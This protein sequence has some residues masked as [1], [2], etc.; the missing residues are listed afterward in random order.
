MKKVLAPV[1]HHDLYTNT[2]QKDLIGYFEEVLIVPIEARLSDR[3]GRKINATDSGLKA[4]LASGAIWYADGAFRGTF[5]AESSRELTRMG[6]KHRARSQ[7]FV[8]ELA[9][10]PLDVRQSIYES[11]DASKK[12]IAG[13]AAL[14]LMMR[15]NVEESDTGIDVKRTEKL[16][17]DAANGEFNRAMQ[18]FDITRNPI[19]IPSEMQAVA[20]EI[21]E[22]LKADAKRVMAE[23]LDRLHREL[24]ALEQTG[25]PLDA[26]KK[27]IEKS[28]QR[29]LNRTS[30][31][32]EHAAALLLSEYR[33]KQAARLGLNN[34]IWKTMRDNRVR[35]DHRELE[36]KEFS[37]SSPPVTNRKT[38]AHNHPGEDINCIPGDSSI[39]FAHGIKK[40]FRRWYDGKLTLVVFES[41]KTLRITPNHHVLTSKGWKS[42]KSLNLGDD[43]VNLT[44][45]LIPPSE[46]NKDNSVSSIAEI[47][48]AL[49]EL[50]PKKRRAGLGM[51]FHGD[52]T[53]A[54]VDVVS[55]ANSLSLWRHILSFFKNK[56]F[57][58]SD[59]FRLC[60][61]K[62]KP[63]L[64]P[65]WLR[66]FSGFEG[67][68]E[69]RFFIHFGKPNGVCGTSLSGGNPIPKQTGPNG[70]PANGEFS[71]AGQFAKTGIVVHQ[72]SGFIN[73]LSVQCRLS[74][75]R[76]WHS[77][78]DHALSKGVLI[79]AEA[80]ARRAKSSSGF[81]KVDRV[82]SVSHMD[83]SG[84]VYNLETSC[85]WY[86][87]NGHII[88]NCRCV[89]LN[90]INLP[91]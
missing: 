73:W 88:H 70:I 4:A 22:A 87:C 89:P 49:S 77:L 75:E 48:N 17:L 64:L 30:T 41:G 9:D 80:L 15:S 90:I 61:S 26:L 79:D 34:Y 32:A 10:I 31:M 59:L 19:G 16:I 51:D 45:D 63:T 39:D 86:S 83:F 14:V 2:I 33:K 52:G 1:I 7:A 81:N 71:S 23:E 21:N 46:A 56:T 42:A 12:A 76:I 11:K 74:A 58:K 69:K 8:I 3:E 50:F 54:D 91:D 82:I 44:G 5:N 47:F 84:H 66:C 35:H 55:T 20:D 6:A 62:Q 24:T 25:A 78:F 72:K 37:W 38:G 27:T 18:D 67:K 60:S 57:P 53:N 28:K 68:I 65:S 29:V 40:A 13:A 43:V 36:G 85:E